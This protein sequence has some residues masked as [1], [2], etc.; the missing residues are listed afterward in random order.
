MGFLLTFFE[1]LYGLLRKAL[2]I[3]SSLGSQIVTAIG[4]VVAV[5]GTMFGNFT[6]LDG[7]TS[8]VNNATSVVSNFVNASHSDLFEIFF[9]WFAVDT[10]VQVCGVV[11]SATFGVAVVVFVT[12]FT[13]VFGLV[14]VVLGVRAICKALQTVSVGYVKP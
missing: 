1:W 9:G 8:W 6:W 4:S 12:I 5:V 2:S 13:A 11:V 3:V 10:F 14:P 7:A